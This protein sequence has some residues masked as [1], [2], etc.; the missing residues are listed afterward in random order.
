M[1]LTSKQV[2]DQIINL[3]TNPQSLDTDNEG[4]LVVY[5][6]VYLW[7]DETFHNEPEPQ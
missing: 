1:T 6:G 7:K 3:V 5:T 2:V 4:Q